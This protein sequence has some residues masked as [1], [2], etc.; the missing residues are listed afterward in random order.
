VLIAAST[1]QT[2]NLLRRSGLKARALGEHFQCHAAYG[3]GGVFDEPVE[4]NFGATQG[5]ESVHL[6]RSERIKLET[7]SMPPELAAVRIPGVGR[8]LMRRLGVFAHL[9][10]WALGVRAEAEGTVTPGWGGRD[11]IKWTPTT[12]D[13]EHARRAVALLAR[14]MFEAGAREVWPGLHGVPSTIA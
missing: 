7:L 1:V 12:V 2:P 9:A 5:A 3:I 11:R 13:V 4:M 6:R 8:E 10:V 14:M